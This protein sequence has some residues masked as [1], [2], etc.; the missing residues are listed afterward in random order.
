MNK[1]RRQCLSRLSQAPQG[2]ENCVELKY[3][4]SQLTDQAWLY[5]KK[6]YP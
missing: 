4:A 1:T 6:H 3:M 5:L 2:A